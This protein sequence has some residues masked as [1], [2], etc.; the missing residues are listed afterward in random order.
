MAKTAR[1]DP[2]EFFQ[3]TAYYGSQGRGLFTLDNI[4]NKVKESI[5]AGEDVVDAVDGP[6]GLLTTGLVAKTISSPS[7]SLATFEEFSYIG[8]TR[9]HP[10]TQ[11]FGPIT[12]EFYLMGSSITEA[13]AI[14][15]T[16]LRWQEAIA[17]PRFPTNSGDRGVRSDSTY[18]SIEYYDDYVT[19]AEFAVYS[20]QDL[21]NPIIHNK[22]YEIYPRSVNGIQTSWDSQ[23]A[24]LT[25]SVE[26]EFYYMQ[27]R[28]GF[29]SYT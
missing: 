4:P 3:K 26:F 13:R 9:K 20:P 10:H 1:F 12:V 11:I 23:D 18:Y 19:N 6:T 7:S 16:F 17:G 8:P 29:I 14:Y 27:S 2:Q 24:P 15:L 22:Y 25:L 21:S 28:L 5:R